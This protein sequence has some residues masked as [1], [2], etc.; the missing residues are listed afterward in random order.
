[1]RS[2]QVCECGA[3]AQGSW[4]SPTPAAG[5]HPGAGQGFSPP[6]SVHSDIHI[7]NG[8][9]ELG[10]RQTAAAAGPRH[11]TAAHHGTRETW[12][13]VVAAGPDAHD[14]TIGAITVWVHP[15][16][17]LQRLRHGAGVGMRTFARRRAN[18]GVFSD[19]GYADY[20]VV[21]HPRYLF[22]IG[23]LSPTQAAPARVLRHYSLWRASRRSER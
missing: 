12:A 9:Y 6:A 14:V 3:P 16:I 4:S 22:D 21:P 10:R 20:L 7:W 18:L 5:W 1:M 13:K 8:Y 23:E 15:W 19:G 2:F 17:G 11:Q